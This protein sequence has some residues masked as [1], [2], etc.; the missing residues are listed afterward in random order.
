MP[1]LTRL[2]RPADAAAILRLNAAFDDVRASVEH[3][4]EHIAQRSHYETPFVA[5]IDDQ[6]VG[7]ACLRLIPMLCD[8]IPSAELTEL[9]VDP[10]FRR[11]GVG[12][13]LVH[14]VEQAAHDQGA[15]M[16]ALIT[17]WHNT[18]AHAFYHA[19]GYR[20]YTI[21]M[22]RSLEKLGDEA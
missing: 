11:Q 4:D 10:H 19:I 22:Q 6:V 9:I 15:T 8:P 13:A 17:A 7:L 1:I 16:L 14:H 12:R 21:S 3:I 20:L 18:Q 2:A 5:T